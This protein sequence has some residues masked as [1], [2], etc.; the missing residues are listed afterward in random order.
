MHAPLG[1]GWRQLLSAMT[2]ARTRW[3][4]TPDAVDSYQW[5]REFTKAHIAIRGFYCSA[6]DSKRQ[7]GCLWTWFALYT[8]LGS[9]HIIKG[10]YNSCMCAILMD[11][12]CEYV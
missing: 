1:V 2:P 4:T 3:W 10:G 8:G 9:Q 7:R 12:T 11:S 6:S 5:N